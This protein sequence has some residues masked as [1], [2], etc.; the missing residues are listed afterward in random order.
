MEYL[1]IRRLP[2]LLRRPILPPL[3]L[4]TRRQIQ[5]VPGLQILIQ[6]LLELGIADL[7]NGSI[8]LALS[9]TCLEHI[10]VLFEFLF[11]VLVSEN[12][13]VVFSHIQLLIL[14]PLLLIAI[15]G[16]IHNYRDASC[17]PQAN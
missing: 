16:N 14:L 10:C 6:I 5:L 11:D 3:L 8:K 15:F 17:D 9:S 13:S 2:H 4:L 7:L 12:F 1:L